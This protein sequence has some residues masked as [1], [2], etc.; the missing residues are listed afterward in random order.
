MTI[1]EA[2]ITLDRV[3]ARRMWLLQAPQC[4]APSDINRQ[5]QQIDPSEF[6]EPAEHLRPD[7]K[8]NE[9]KKRSESLDADQVLI[10][11]MDD[12][13]AEFGRLEDYE[14]RALSRRKQAIRDFDATT[15]W[16]KR[17]GLKEI[18]TILS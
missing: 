1:A 14:R 7:I 5:F 10:A 8:I 3:R 4:P 15:P 16:R 13:K 9:K 11:A 18:S 2:Q 17:R 6:L 12:Q